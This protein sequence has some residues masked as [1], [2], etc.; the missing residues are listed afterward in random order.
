MMFKRRM[1]RSVDSEFI[2][3]IAGVLLACTAAAGSAAAPAAGKPHRIELPGKAALEMVWIS[4]GGFTMGSPAS[5]PDRRADEAP[6][7]KV[8]LSKGFWLGR[9]PVTIGQ[10]QAV[11]GQDVRGQL[12]RVIDDDTLY[13]LGGKRQTKRDYMRFSRERAAEYL[14]GVGADL[15][16]YFVSWDD[17]MEFGRRL[18]AL[19]REAARFRPDTNTRFQ[20][21]HSGN[22]RFAPARAAPS[23]PNLLAQSPGTPRTVPTATAARASRLR[24]VHRRST[25][26]RRQAA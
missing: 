2:A 18:T 17:A 26:R 4:P 21:R 15:P 24:P 20:P 8:T 1:P 19:E 25:R 7:T 22:T 6:Q 9:T 5:E 23:M 14:A 13:D 12:M 11:M 10:W 16:M 3:R